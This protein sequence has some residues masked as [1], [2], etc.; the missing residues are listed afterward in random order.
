MKE[1]KRI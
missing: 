1:Q